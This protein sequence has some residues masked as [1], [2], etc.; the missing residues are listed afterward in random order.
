LILFQKK[1]LTQVGRKTLLKR[2]LLLVKKKKQLMKRLLKLKQRR[3]KPRK[4]KNIMALRLMSKKE[5][6]C[7]IR[8]LKLKLLSFR[9]ALKR[10]DLTRRKD[11]SSTRLSDSPT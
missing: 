1:T 3:Q 2:S 7:L 4:R 5:T 9:D 8:T 10:K 11:A 6:G